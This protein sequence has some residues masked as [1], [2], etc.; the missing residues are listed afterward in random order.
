MSKLEKSKIDMS[1]EEIV[2]SLI[3]DFQNDISLNSSRQEVPS[4]SLSDEAL[5]SN[6]A[7]S[8]A[9]PV[10]KEPKIIELEDSKQTSPT[11]TAD[12]NIK[13]TTQNA[14]KNEIDT[15]LSDINSEVDF[16]S[17]GDKD[18]EIVEPE[19]SISEDVSDN[20]GTD[21]TDLSVEEIKKLEQTAISLKDEGNAL[22]RLNQWSESLAKY[23]EALRSCPRSCS[24]SRAVFYANRSAALEKLEKPDQSI[25]ACSK[26]ITLN[27]SYL[28]VYQRRARLYQQS[29]K[30]DEALA[31]YQKILE[32]DP[33]NRDAFVATK[34]LPQQINERNEKM[35]EEM[36]GKLKDLGNMI[37]RPF[38]LSTNNFQMVQD[39]NSG[40]YSINFKQNAPPPS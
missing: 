18:N 15:A 14:T 34:T 20:E 32:L 25:L 33:N 2:N 39:P 19:P 36:L 11:N 13:T 40:G 24:V 6:S 30:L 8:T 1:N 29:D 5:V 12:L 27:P 17:D 16:D 3:E 22:F 7:K 23:N 35:K 26:A 4:D 9:S 21:D 38:G 31:D 28:K 10:Y 37:L